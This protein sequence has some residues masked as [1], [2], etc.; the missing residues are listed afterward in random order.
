MPIAVMVTVS[1]LSSKIL[2]SLSLS[3]LLSL[4]MIFAFGAASLLWQRPTMEVRREKEQGAVPG[5][6]AVV[7]AKVTKFSIWF[8]V[9]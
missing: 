8:F 9:A 7:T 1:K 4:C 2:L 5:P 3:S 6:G